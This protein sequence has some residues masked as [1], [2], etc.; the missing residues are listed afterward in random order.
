MVA[1]CTLAFALPRCVLRI[2]ASDEARCRFD[3]KLGD[4]HRTLMTYSAAA[5]IS[6]CRKM[7]WPYNSPPPSLDCYGRSS[8]ARAHTLLA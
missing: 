2:L 4:K 5:A 1:G 6:F 8:V 3:I 7:I